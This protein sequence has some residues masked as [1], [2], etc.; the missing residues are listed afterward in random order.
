[1]SEERVVM[2]GYVACPYD[3]TDGVGW[4]YISSATGDSV[5]LDGNWSEPQLPEG[6]VI[7]IGEPF[8]DS[9]G[10]TRYKV[11]HK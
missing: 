9:D 11:I 5:L 1:M 8:K 4:T 10:D 6:S 3:D 7:V 2:V